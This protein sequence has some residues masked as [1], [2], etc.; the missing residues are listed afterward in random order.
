MNNKSLLLW[1]FLGFDQGGRH[2]ERSAAQKWHLTQSSQENNQY[3]HD[4][5]DSRKQPFHNVLSVNDWWRALRAIWGMENSQIETEETC[6]CLTSKKLKSRHEKLNP[7]PIFSCKNGRP[8]HRHHHHLHQSNMT[9]IQEFTLFTVVI[10]NTRENFRLQCADFYFTE[11]RTTRSTI[12]Q[13]DE[14]LFIKY[15]LQARLGLLLNHRNF[16]WT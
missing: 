14:L 5:Y 7:S 6:L 16:C 8:H 10:M 4:V 11:T 3:L 1:I 15:D 12:F 13:T 2:R 9:Q